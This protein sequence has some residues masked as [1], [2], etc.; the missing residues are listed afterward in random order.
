MDSPTVSFF[1]E[2]WPYTHKHAPLGGIKLQ[3]L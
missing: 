3:T 2:S 1:S